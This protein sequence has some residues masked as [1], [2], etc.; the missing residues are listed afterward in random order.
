M[1]LLKPLNGIGIAVEAVD[2]NL[3]SQLEVIDG[4]VTK[5]DRLLYCYEIL[6]L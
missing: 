5:Q 1:Q 6:M 3:V 2:Q 4:I